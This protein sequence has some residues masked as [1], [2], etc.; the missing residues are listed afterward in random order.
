MREGGVVV[1]ATPF[2]WLDEFTPRSEWLGGYEDE[3]GAPVHSKDVLKRE[4]EL[5]GFEKIH[6][7]QMPA[8]IR[9]H[10]RKYQYIVS[11]ATAWR[12]L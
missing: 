7:E 3:R 1:L 12:K 5:R 10:Q 11:E 2:S 4:M 8:L 6:E 9:E